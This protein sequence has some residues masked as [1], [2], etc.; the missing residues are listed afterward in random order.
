MCGGGDFCTVSHNSALEP[1]NPSVLGTNA[2][3]NSPI[4]DEYHRFWPCYENGVIKT[5]QT[6]PHNLYVSIK[7]TS[8]YCGLRI[9]QDNPNLQYLYHLLQH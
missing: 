5:I 3:H 7:L 4:F 6:V 1:V 8:L 9:N 2:A